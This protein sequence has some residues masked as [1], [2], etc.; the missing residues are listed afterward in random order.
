M[1]GLIDPDLLFPAE[2][3][4]PCAGAEAICRSKRSSRSS[5][6]TGIRSRLYALDEPFPDPAQLLIVPDSLCVPHCCS[7]RGSG[8]KSSAFRRST[9]R[10]VET[11]GPRDLAAFSART[12]ISF[13]ARRRGFGSTIRSPSFSAST[14]LPPPP[15][16]TGFTT[17]SRLSG[18][19]GLSPRARLRA[20][21][22]RGD[23]H[24]RQCPGRFW[25]WHGKIL[26]SGWKGR[27]VP[28]Y[29]PDGRCRS[30]FPGFFDQS[31][32]AR[33]HHAPTPQ[34]GR[35]IWTPIAPAAP[36]SRISA[37]PRRITAMRRQTRPTFRKRRPRHSS[38]GC[39]W[40]RRIADERRLFRR[41]C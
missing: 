11:D 36:I 14:K 20:L 34:R 19:P 40:A 15:V 4:H 16:R 28:A 27:V 8:W 29:R 33:R 10:R 30:G 17:T 35:A 21:Q 18:A 38:T 6:A 5:A 23:L 31:R 25:A 7:A 24:D 22:Y 26:E 37:R 39:G 13:A 41:R 1:R 32:Q 12:T 2:R 9:V 3:A